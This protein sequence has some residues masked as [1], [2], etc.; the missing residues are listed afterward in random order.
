MPTVTPITDEAA[1]NL[2]AVMMITATQDTGLSVVHHGQHH[3]LGKISVIANCSGDCFLVQAG[4]SRGITAPPDTSRRS[5]RPLATPG[6]HREDFVEGESLS[7]SPC[8][9]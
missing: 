4:R 8:R 2:I 7:S 3:Q 5:L 6:G 1:A 9:C